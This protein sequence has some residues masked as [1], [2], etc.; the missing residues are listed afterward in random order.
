MKYV[1]KN[2]RRLFVN[3]W[4]KLFMRMD[5]LQKRINQLKIAETIDAVVQKYYAEKGLPVPLWKRHKVTWW[6]EYLI[7]LGM[8]PNNP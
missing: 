6:E 7:S 3:N 5:V 8:D 2:V 1:T 4:K